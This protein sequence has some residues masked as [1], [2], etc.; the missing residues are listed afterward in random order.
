MDS[1][2]SWNDIIAAVKI[3]A[4]GRLSAVDGMET[5]PMQTSCLKADPGRIVTINHFTASRGKGG[6]VSG[7]VGGIARAEKSNICR[8]MESE[9]Q[10]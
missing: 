1:L 10:L 8:F 5:P 9:P 3:E 7:Q 6:W 4:C 2:G